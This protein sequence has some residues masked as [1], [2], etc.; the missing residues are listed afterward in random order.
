MSGTFGGVYVDEQRAAENLAALI[1]KY[2]V[3]VPPSALIIMFRERWTTLSVLAHALHN[4]LERKRAAAD[5]YAELYL[6]EHE[7]KSG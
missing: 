6:P 7:A 1:N 5:Q 2:D 4:A 3:C